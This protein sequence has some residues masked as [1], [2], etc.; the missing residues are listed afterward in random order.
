MKPLPFNDDPRNV[1][2]NVVWF[3]PP[4]RALADPILPAADGQF[5]SAIAT[6]LR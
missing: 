2:P 6:A 3:E 4:Q 5:E 1:A